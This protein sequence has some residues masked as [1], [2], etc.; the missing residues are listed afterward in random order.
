MIRDSTENQDSNKC[1]SVEKKNDQ[2][3]EKNQATEIAILRTSFQLQQ[4]VGAGKCRHRCN[5]EKETSLIC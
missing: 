4:Q 5:L 3:E 2:N 1:S